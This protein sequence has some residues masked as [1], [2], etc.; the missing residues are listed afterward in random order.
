MKQNFAIFDFDKTLTKRDT[1][2]IAWEFAI[3][4][5]LTSKSEYLKNLTIA[6][7]KYLKS[8]KFV[9]FKSQICQVFNFY[10]DS[11]L[12]ELAN[13]IIEN[14]LLEDGIEYLKNLDSDKKLLVSASPEIYLNYVN[15]YLGFD[16]VIGTVLNSDYTLNSNNR[17][18]EKVKRIEE[19]LEENSLSIDYDNSSAYSDS[20][21]SDRPML[22]LVKNKFLINSRKHHEG[23]KNL[24]WD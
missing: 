21:K 7:T 24:Y 12:R 18:S 5:N 2:P 19:Y 16:H 9:D 8:K 14:Y 3:K 13:Y 10:N 15:E 22:E 1:L 20:L 23:Y 17:S 11:S 4:K 6:S